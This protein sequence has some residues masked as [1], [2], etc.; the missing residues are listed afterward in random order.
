MCVCVCLYIIEYQ[1][2]T[3]EQNLFY[4]PTQILKWVALLL[5]LGVFSNV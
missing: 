5:K 2:L 3:H 4:C 1:I